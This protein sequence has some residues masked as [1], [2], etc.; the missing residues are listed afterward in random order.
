M[1]TIDYE[2][3]QSDKFPIGYRCPVCGNEVSL[4]ESLNGEAVLCMRCPNEEY[5]V[6]VPVWDDEF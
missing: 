1:E 4:N 6:M 3:E 2:N 5:T